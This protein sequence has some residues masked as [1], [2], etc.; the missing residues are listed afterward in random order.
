MPTIIT[1]TIDA[2]GQVEVEATGTRDCEE[3]RRVI[4]AALTT[5]ETPSMRLHAAGED[6]EMTSMTTDAKPIP[7]RVMYDGAGQVVDLAGAADAVKW[8]AQLWAGGNFDCGP[9]DYEY[10][11]KEAVS[12]LDVARELPSSKT[13]LHRG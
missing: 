4:D 6:E 9:Q 11:V 13:P 2:D 3:L 12:L 7:I 10:M 1:V 8:F 5:L